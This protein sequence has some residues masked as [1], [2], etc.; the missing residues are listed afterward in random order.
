MD[1]LSH[2]G[3]KEKRKRLLLTTL[4]LIGNFST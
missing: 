3:E 1:M 2:S 4:L